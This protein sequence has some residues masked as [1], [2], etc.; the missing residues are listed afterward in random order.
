MCFGCGRNGD[1]TGG[2]SIYGN[3]TNRWKFADEN[4]KLK[5]TRPMLLSMANS[6]PN[7]NGS[8]FFLC[9]K[10]TPWLDGRHAVFGKVVK[11][12]DVLKQLE[13]VGTPDAPP[14][15]GKPT[16]EVTFDIEVVSKRDH[17]YAVK[18]L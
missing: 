9:F 7:T 16:E 4:F 5:H 10:A 15:L 11:G 17:P 1:G 12:L 6:G 14:T 18:K 2:R 8:Q 13:A 3:E